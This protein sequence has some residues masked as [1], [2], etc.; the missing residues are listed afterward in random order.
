M[1][2]MALVEHLERV[3]TT[4]TC[5]RIERGTIWICRLLRATGRRCWLKHIIS[6]TSRRVK[7]TRGRKHH[8]RTELAICPDV[9]LDIVTHGCVPGGRPRYTRV[10]YGRETVGGSTCTAHTGALRAPDHNMV[11]E[12]SNVPRQ[13]H[14]HCPLL[15]STTRPKDRPAARLFVHIL[16]NVGKPVV[17]TIRFSRC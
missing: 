9:T 6:A 14:S 16:R 3:A 10:C 15:H 8:A 17:A 4:T 2:P 13:P 5:D 11:A 12:Q 1:L 7:T